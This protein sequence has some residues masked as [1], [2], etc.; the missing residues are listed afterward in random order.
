MNNNIQNQTPEPLPA[1]PE[2]PDRLTRR[3]R[4]WEQRREARAA[5]LGG[6]WVAGVILIVLGI[7]ILLQN[8]NLFT[9]HNWWAL[10][11]LIPAAGAFG[12]AWK[13]YQDVGGRLTA[14]ARGSLVAGLILTM[15]SAVFLFNLEWS[16]LGPV[17]IILAGLGLLLNTLLPG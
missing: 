14:G 17:L 5:R 4:R 12:A 1:Q 10:F 11:I 16:I 13:T 9:L 6:P 8:L 2:Y 3:Q 7:L 15:V